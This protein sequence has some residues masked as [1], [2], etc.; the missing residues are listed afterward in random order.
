MDQAPPLP[1]NKPNAAAGG[2]PSDEAT[3]EALRTLRAAHT[4]PGPY[5]FKAIGANDAAF[6][7]ACLQAVVAVLGPASTPEVQTRPSAHGRHQAV[8]LR[9]QVRS[10]EQVVEIYGLLRATPGL[11]LLL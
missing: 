11:K 6:T 10:A 4:F 5:G 3:A 8:H 2:P 9:A 7:A 1:P